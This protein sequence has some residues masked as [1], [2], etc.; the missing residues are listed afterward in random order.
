MKGE[1]TRGGVEVKEGWRVEKKEGWRVKGKKG[2]RLE[3]RKTKS[4]R[5][6]LN[7]RISDMY[8]QPKQY[9]VK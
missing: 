7:Y 5:S 4:V 1:R 9:S 3:V 6:P 8:K 2:R